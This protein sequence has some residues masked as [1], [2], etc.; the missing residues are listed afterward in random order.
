MATALLLGPTFIALR[1]LRQE[2]LEQ[3]GL[4]VTRKGHWQW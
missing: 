2:Q 4:A 1:H 3:M